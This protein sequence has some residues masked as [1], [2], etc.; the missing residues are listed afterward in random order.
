VTTVIGFTVAAV[1]AGS[2]VTGY[3]IRYRASAALSVSMERQR[4][5]FDGPLPVLPGQ[6]RGL[7]ALDVGETVQRLGKW[8]AAV[9]GVIAILG[10]FSD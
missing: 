4:G 1:G 7:K 5:D 3:L 9:G 8:T 2:Y 10:L 6:Q